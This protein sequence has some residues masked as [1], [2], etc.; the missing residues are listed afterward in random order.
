MRSHREPRSWIWVIAQLV[1]IFSSFFARALSYYPERT[2][3]WEIPIQVICFPSTLLDFGCIYAGAHP[4]KVHVSQEQ[5]LA[6]P[7][8][9]KGMI[10]LVSLVGL[11]G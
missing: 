3:G 5:R 2:A 10:A 6:L 8:E 7:T 9:K 4:G 1:K 11:P